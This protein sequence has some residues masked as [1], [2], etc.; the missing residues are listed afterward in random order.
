MFYQLT[1]DN[2]TLEDMASKLIKIIFFGSLFLFFNCTQ[3][4]IIKD[5][6]VITYRSVPAPDNI[7]FTIDPGIDSHLIEYIEILGED[8]R[9]IKFYSFQLE[10][11]KNRYSY[12]IRTSDFINNFRNAD[13]IRDYLMK[14]KLTL[15]LENGKFL[16]YQFYSK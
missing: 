12:K 13:E 10:N 4:Y 9:S 1:K 2:N 3:L 15:K 16:D 7:V 8:S 11:V 5:I 6:E 14:S